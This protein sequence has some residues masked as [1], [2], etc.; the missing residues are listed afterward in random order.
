MLV[1]LAKSD[2][3][4]IISLKGSRLALTDPGSTSGALLPRKQFVGRVGMTLENYFRVV[5]YSGSH[6]KSVQA[7]A[8]GAVDA[9]FIASAQLEEAHVAGKLRK[10]DVR[11]LW[12][13]GPSRMIR[14]SIADSCANR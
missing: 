14:R 12:T 9:A 2:F 3:N 13:S 4:D 8:G 5:S 6:A 7:L 1:V 10:G 11:V